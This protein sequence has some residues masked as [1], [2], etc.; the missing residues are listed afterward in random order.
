MSNRGIKK[1]SERCDLIP[2]WL[3]DCPQNPRMR[4]PG[5]WLGQYES[6]QANKRI[7]QTRTTMELIKI[8]EIQM[9][10]TRQKLN[11]KGECKKTSGF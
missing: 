2:R 8:T 7:R 6:C 3:D 4:I 9:Q 10:K 1:L 5:T 11:Y